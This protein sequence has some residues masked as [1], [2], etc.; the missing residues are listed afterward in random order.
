VT[1]SYTVNINYSLAKP[2]T[3]DERK[4]LEKIINNKHYNNIVTEHIKNKLEEAFKN[5]NLPVIFELLSKLV[6][7]SRCYIENLKGGEIAQNIIGAHFDIYTLYKFFE[8]NI[9]S[10]V[11][12]PNMK[13]NTPLLLNSYEDSDLSNT[14]LT[15]L[16]PNF[17]KSKTYEEYNTVNEDVTSNNERKKRRVGNKRRLK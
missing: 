4:I 9:I 5:C 6:N 10:N 15:K 16:F 12:I 7:S 2:Y 14:S 11:D 3:E 17:N 13:K 8:K 1:I